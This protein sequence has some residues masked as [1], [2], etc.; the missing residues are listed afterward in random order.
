MPTQFKIGHIEATFY[1]S[2]DI[3]DPIKTDFM[4]LVQVE[5]DKVS[6]NVAQSDCKT[7]R[8]MFWL[9]KFASIASNGVDKTKFQTDF[10]RKHNGLFLTRDIVKNQVEFLKELVI[11]CP[12]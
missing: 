6:R 1:T 11:F 7:L 10:T 12:N 2:L 5:A 3:S 8:S 9:Q 4:A